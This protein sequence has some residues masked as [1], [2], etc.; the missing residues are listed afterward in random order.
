MFN[1]VPTRT[2]RSSSTELPSSCLPPHVLVPGVILLQCRI[3]YISHWTSWDSCQPSSGLLKTPWMAAWPSHESATPCSFMSPTNL[4]RV[5]TTPSSRLLM[6]MLNRTEPSTDH[7]ST[8]LITGLQLDFSPVTTTL[9]T[10]LFCQFLIH[11]IAHPAH[12]STVSLQGCYK[13][14][15]QRPYWSSGSPAIS[16]AVSYPSGWSFN[17]RS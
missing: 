17:Y 14:Q 7:W 16:T 12:N 13:G 10:Q 9:C 15:C 8:V 11:L 6:R 5:Y 2:P 1:L 4:L 3:L